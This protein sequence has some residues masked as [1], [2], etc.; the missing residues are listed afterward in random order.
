MG[1]G[2]R[3]QQVDA[4][5]CGDGPVIVLTGAIDACE[6]LLMKQA[7]QSVTAGHHLQGSS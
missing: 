3:I 6:G 5:V 4:V 1:C 7:L 2:A